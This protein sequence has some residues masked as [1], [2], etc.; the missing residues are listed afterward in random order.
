VKLA[1]QLVLGFLMASS[2]AHAA[3]SKQDWGNTA[4]GQSV[5]IYTLSDSYMSVRLTTFGA[6][7][8]SINVPDRS[9][10][11][12]DVALGFSSLAGYEADTS[13]YMGAI[14]GR[15]GNRIAHGKFSVDGKVYQIPLNNGANAIHGGPAGFD[16][17]VWTAHE[18]PE[19]VEMTLVSQSGD[20]GFP[21]TLTVHVRYTLHEKELCIAY[22][23]TTTQATVVNLTNHTY[24]NLSG[25]GSGNILDEVLMLHADRYTPIDAGLIP[26]GELATVKGTPFDFREP[27]SI[28]SRI[29]EPNEQ[30][31]LAG[32]YD[33]NFVL[34][35]GE[36]TDSP[37]VA[38]IVYDPQSGRT[39]T[40]S[41]TQPGVQFYTGNFLDGTLTGKSGSKYERHAGF[42]LETQHF[43][44]SPSHPDFPST[45][46]LPG[47]V[48]RSITR[49]AFGVKS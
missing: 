29:D 43:P 20:M 49:F 26:T 14:V 42:C 11:R 37:H 36:N 10:K 17:K 47:H 28:G 45:V 23:A 2:I 16:R 18:I 40:V 39:L 22:E 38:A 7:L 32:G 44:D 33:H 21:G 19:G 27:T 35:A 12:A 48:F 30:L 31:K 8:V 1:Q 3:V 34:N 13:S 24:F 41:T 15:Y 4:Q 25:E 5:E 6:H 46:L 9:G